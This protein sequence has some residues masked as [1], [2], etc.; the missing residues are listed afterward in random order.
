MVSTTVQAWQRD[1]FASPV[2]PHFGRLQHAIDAFVALAQFTPRTAGDIAFPELG[3]AV[4][5]VVEAAPARASRLDCFTLRGGGVSFGCSARAIG[6][7]SIWSPF[8]SCTRAGLLREWSR[9]CRDAHLEVVPSEEG[10][11]PRYGRA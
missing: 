4:L 9:H 1:M 5:S 8:V 6:Q 2:Q 11:A 10:H 7:I 3:E